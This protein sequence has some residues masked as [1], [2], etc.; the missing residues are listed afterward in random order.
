MPRSDSFGSY[1]RSRGAL[2]C[3]GVRR[4]YSPITR[5]TIWRVRGHDPAMT[6]MTSPCS[7]H[8]ISQRLWDVGSHG[9][10]RRPTPCPRMRILGPP[11]MD[12][13]ADSSSF[14]YA[15]GSEGLSGFGDMTETAEHESMLEL[16]VP[17]T[18]RCLSDRLPSAV[19]SV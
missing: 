11:W 2:V 4:S 5:S 14:A 16:S 8:S 7:V 15:G 1:G 18:S 3:V 13:L 19:R 6:D 10:N 17:Y 9:N 12:D